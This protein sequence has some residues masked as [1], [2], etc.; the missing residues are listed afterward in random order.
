M[1]NRY[2]HQ[3]VLWIDVE[4][5]AE[6]EILALEQEFN[7]GPL[8]AQALLGPTLKPHVDAYPEFAYAV[9]NFPSIRYTHGHATT[10]EIYIIILKKF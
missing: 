6:E 7:L 3:G 8:L 1:V 2:E 5:P 10:Q 9:L 4:A